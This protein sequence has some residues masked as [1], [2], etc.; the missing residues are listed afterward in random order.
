M[1][2]H[3]TQATGGRTRGVAQVLAARPAIEGAGV[4]LRRAFGNA[5]PK[6]D[7]FLLLDDFRSENPAE[8]GAGFPWHP[9]RGIETVTYMLD[10]RVEHGDSIGN[11]GVIGP[12]DVQW[13]SAGSGIIHQEMPKGI[14]GKMGGFQLWINMPKARKMSDPRYQEVKRGSIPEAALAK[15]ARARVI[16]GTVGGVQGPIHDARVMPEYI[17]VQLDPGARLEHAVPEGHNY[18]AYVV[19]GKAAFD[20]E[21]QDFVDSEHLVMLADGDRVAASAGPS[22]ARFLLVGG[23]PLR[24]PVAWYGPMVMNTREEIETAIHEYQE[25]TFIKKGKDRRHITRTP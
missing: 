4:H 5:T 1:T 25:G 21:G 6:L 20:R 24:E 22:G 11:E 3:E 10:G 15:G 17:D 8:F 16:A 9:H 14:E 2:G 18:F 7:P 23:K 19:G 13:M 12:G